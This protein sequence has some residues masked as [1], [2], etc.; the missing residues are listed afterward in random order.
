MGGSTR[1]ASPTDA[2][3]V[4]DIYAT[5]VESTAIL[6]E[7]EPPTVEDR[8]DRIETTLATHPWLVCE[9][10][11]GEIVGFASAS[12]LRSRPAYDWFGEA[13]SG[14]KSLLGREEDALD[15]SETG[16]SRP[17]RLIPA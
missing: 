17:F 9:S 16:V 1:I 11:C 10:E 8:P 12:S 5:F 6:F 14:G 13:I 3:D 7:E 2:P 4:R 15:I